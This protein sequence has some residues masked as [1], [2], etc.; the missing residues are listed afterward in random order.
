MAS[1]PRP[2]RRGLAAAAQPLRPL[3][4]QQ[5]IT[6]DGG[7]RLMTANPGAAAAG[8]GNALAASYHPEALLCFLALEL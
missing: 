1:P 4:Y 6:T 2:G 8:C 7:D 5:E 3:E